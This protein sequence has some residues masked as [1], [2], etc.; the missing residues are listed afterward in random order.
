MRLKEIIF[1]EKELILFENIHFT[2][3]E[4]QNYMLKI[5]NNKDQYNDND[6][7]KL[8]FKMEN[9]RNNKLTK[10]ILNIIKK[11]INY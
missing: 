5:S 1:N 10:S 9:E 2:C 11:Q 8:I 3:D 7:K 6:I 4:L